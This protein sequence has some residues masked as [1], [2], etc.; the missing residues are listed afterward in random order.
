MYANVG[1][2]LSM[3]K[4]ANGICISGV[5]PGFEIR[6]GENGK[7]QEKMGAGKLYKYI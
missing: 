5:D 1:I 4:C 6:G 3:P 7:F 2:I